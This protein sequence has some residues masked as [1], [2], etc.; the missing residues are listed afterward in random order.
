MTQR[1]DHD[2]VDAVMIECLENLRRIERSGSF[3]SHLHPAQ[4]MLQARSGTR[5][6]AHYARD[7]LRASSRALR[8]D[9]WRRPKAASDE[10][11]ASGSPMSATNPRVSPAWWKVLSPEDA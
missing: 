3:I 7:A 9:R 4:R 11:R 5:R 1:A 2:V 10:P 6:A 8:R